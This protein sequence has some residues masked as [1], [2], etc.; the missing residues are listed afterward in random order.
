LAERVSTQ[1]PEKS[2]DEPGALGVGGAL[3]M[4]VANLEWRASLGLD[5]LADMSLA[6]V[7]GV[8]ERVM[9]HWYP[10]WHDGLDR[11]GRPVGWAKLGAFDV[12]A[13]SKTVPLERLRMFHLW[14]RERMC[15]RLRKASALRGERIDRMT[16]VLDLKHW[17]T[18]LMSRAALAFA[19]E[20][21]GLDTELFAQRV[22]T[23][24]VINAPFM[25]SACWAL[26]TPFMGKDTLDKVKLFSAD[27]LWRP[28]LLAAIEPSE[29]PVEYGG[30]H[31]VAMR[32]LGTPAPPPNVG[33][34]VAAARVEPDVGFI[35]AAR[36]GC[37]G[38]GRQ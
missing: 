13:V 29:M 10:A 1:L 37:M 21:M 23:V 35:A 34:L 31:H 26:L 19:E 6:Q 3:A 16:L 15:R 12:A 8:D 5:A 22:G 33:V 28:A 2:T 38:A 4:L 36:C 32:D 20:L 11:A 25:F 30:T 14:E 9:A 27:A 18:R 24:Y 17:G 7:T